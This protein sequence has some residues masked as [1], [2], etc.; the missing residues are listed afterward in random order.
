V[1]AEAL[2][3]TADG[4]AEEDDRRRGPRRVELMPEHA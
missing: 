1:A 4:D 2:D 3:Q